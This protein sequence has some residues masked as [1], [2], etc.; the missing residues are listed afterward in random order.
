ML[1][2]LLIYAVLMT[3][4]LLIGCASAKRAV[5]F[6]HNSKTGETIQQGEVAKSANIS[7][8]DTVSKIPFVPGSVIT[9]RI[10]DESSASVGTAARQTDIPAAIIAEHRELI[11]TPTTFD[12]PTPSE[13]AKGK[14]VL[15]FY[16]VGGFLALAACALAYLE[17]GKAAIIAGVGAIAI[18]CLANFFSS[19][20]ALRAVVGV[21][22]LSGGLFAAWHFVKHRIEETNTKKK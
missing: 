9:I 14:G 6:T 22:C 10:P 13:I 5:T 7:T 1:K 4:A 8:S 20:W 21:L 15:V 12:P 18:P 11:S 17:H 2:L 16:Y 3:L 19:E